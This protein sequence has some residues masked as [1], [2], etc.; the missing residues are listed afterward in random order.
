MFQ[1]LHPNKFKNFLAKLLSR[2]QKIAYGL[3]SKYMMKEK[4]DVILKK[5]DRVALIYPSQDPGA[6]AAAFFA[7]LFAN[8]VPVPVEAPIS[9][10]V[11]GA[12]NHRKSKHIS[13]LDLNQINEN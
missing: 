4:G 3:M 10:M 6:F 11:R 2:T 5:G 13:H 12:T 9:N 7:C 1:Q 8:L